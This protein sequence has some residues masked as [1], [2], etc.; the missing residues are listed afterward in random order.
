MVN[1]YFKSLI[2]ASL[3]IIFSLSANPVVAHE[4]H[5]HALPEG[6]QK[7]TVATGLKQSTGMAQTPD[8]RIFVIEKAGTVRVIKNSQLL[9]T[10]ALTLPVN[11]EGERGLLGITFDP[12]F[13]SNQYMY[14]Y[15]TNANPL[16]NRVSRF[17]VSGDT[18]VASTEKIILKSEQPI[19]IYHHSGTL[20]FGPDGKLWISVGNNDDG[21]NA[22][23]QDLSN[24][25]GKI[26]RINA[27]GT[28]PSDNPFVGQAGK[29]GEIWAYGFRNPFR[30]SFSGSQPIVGDVGNNLFEEINVVQKGG[31]YGWPNAEGPCT[32]TCPYINPL[33]SYAHTPN[34]NEGA[35]S[36]ITGGLFYK[37]NTGQYAFPSIYNGRYF[38]GDYAKGVI[39][40]LIFDNNGDF[41]T[42]ADFDAEAGSVVDFLQ[43]PDGSLYF[44]TIYTYP[45]FAN[46]GTVQQ[47]RYDGST[48][49]PPVAVITSDQTAGA[50]P[51]TVH[52]TGDTSYDPE[53]KPLTYLW[54]F[55]DGSTSTEANPTHTYT[56]N[57]TYTTSLTVN[58]GQ[59]TGSTISSPIGVGVIMPTVTITSPVDMS[60]YDAGQTIS[61]NATVKD[62]DGNDLPDSAYS[63]LIVFH[64][65]EHVHPF[66]GPITGVKNGTFTP[67]DTGEE[68]VN[69]WYEIALTV[70]DSSGFTKTVRSNIHPNLTTLTFAALP[71]DAGLTFTRNGNPQTFPLTIQSVV[72]FKW[73]V[74]LAPT[75]TVGNSNYRFLSW[76]DNGDMT[77]TITATAAATTYTAQFSKNEVGKGSVQ[78]RIREFDADGKFTG[79][80]LNGITAKLTEPGTGKVT[81]ASATS[82][83]IGDEAGWILFQNVDAGS[84]GA[85]AFA[86]GYVG[87][88]KQTNCTTGGTT[89][90]ATINN[91]NTTN[92]PAG[93][94]NPI[95]VTANQ[96]T[97]CIDI[98]LRP[99]DKG[100]LAFRTRQVEKQADYLGNIIYPT[101]GYLN[102]ITVKLT[103]TTGKTVLK[104]ATSAPINT[105]DGWVVFTDVPQ[106]MYGIIGY[107]TGVSGVWKQID[108]GQGY[109]TANASITNENTEN[110]MAAFKNTVQIIGG[111]TNYCHDLGFVPKA[112]KISFRVREMD[113]AGKWT[114]KFIN[115]ATAK[116]TNTGITTAVQT[117][118]SKTANGGDGWVEF[119]N[120]TAGDYATIVYKTGFKGNW[121]QTN[122][123]TGG[124]T[125]DVTIQNS[126][127]DQNIAGAQK[128][129]RVEAGK[130]TWCSDIGLTS[131]QSIGKGAI[132]YRV[133]TFD[134]SG[135]P[136][137]FLN[138]ATAKLTDPAG[139]IVYTTAVS[140]TKNG[141]DGWVLFSDVDA[142]KQ[143]GL[144]TYKEGFSGYWKQ[145]DCAAGGTN[146]NSTIQNANTDGKLAGFHAPITVTAGA[147]TWCSDI[148]LKT[149]TST[150]TGAIQLR[151]RG[152]TTDTWNGTFLS[153]VTVKLTDTTGNT[154]IDTQK[155]A[156]D[157]WVKF[158]N[159]PAG[160]Y[161]IMAYTKDWKGHW[162]QTDCG[163]GGTTS[164]ATI[165]NS[166]TENT[167]AAWQ[168]TVSVTAQQTTWCMDM[169]LKNDSSSMNSMTVITPTATP[170]NKPTETPSASDSA[171]NQ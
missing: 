127:T 123:E 60:K 59:T 138:G 100:V 19:G 156:A 47:I 44:V 161:G 48:N 111:I 139:T 136:N 70:T 126:L 168:S 159:V 62:A 63:W 20:R 112:G 118:T 117:A 18:A 158:T 40:Q 171:K 43:A 165:Q 58:D 27:D 151:V 134:A 71:A 9:P 13:A 73:T 150:T 108:C 37:A 130:T 94:Q 167:L 104:T 164:N 97:W 96:I 116:L 154:V 39:R 128:L 153:D 170:T 98:G 33:F 91:S 52:F 107:K 166:N 93:W 64:H 102:G 115:G 152:F 14:V 35:D 68:A 74:N 142:T 42:D 145:T 23:S 82:Q 106:G 4:G 87:V 76:S 155:T 163:N 3:A 24:I 72:G 110:N 28:I 7:S 51:L 114:G 90:N 146:A 137:G 25:H 147:T 79:K 61:Y 105:E 56:Q 67:A 17:T 80:F 69:T 38:F 22:K 101:V 65:G 122:C 8:G 113:T 2:I 95:T 11:A 160:T 144:M 54:N 53:G 50:A 29:K 66:L 57:G 49:Q 77:H 129:I 169:G 143:Y 85:L 55:G 157:G 6:F 125:Q 149:A 103:D 140:G 34:A 26:L 162:K 5:E 131:E 135:Q 89:T 12:N 75:Q 99:A 78:F 141:Q 133:R 31:N 86:P 124:T 46:S 83:N 119:E 92:L 10:S 88:W 41:S 1:N 121:R 148:G 16:Q 109:D 84:Y 21:N 32:S 30:F 15:Y 81:Y 120:V 132:E 36:S 45:N